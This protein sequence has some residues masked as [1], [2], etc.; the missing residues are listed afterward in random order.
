VTA[1]Y[2]RG[3]EVLK[4]D[5]S[6]QPWWTYWWWSIPWQLG[7][8]YDRKIAVN[9]AA[10]IDCK[11]LLHQALVEDAQAFLADPGEAIFTTQ[12]LQFGNQIDPLR[13]PEQGDPPALVP[14]IGKCEN[15]GVGTAHYAAISYVLFS[16]VHPSLPNPLAPVGTPALCLTVGPYPWIYG[17]YSDL[18][19][20]IPN[21]FNIDMDDYIRDWLTQ[22]WISPANDAANVQCNMQYF[23]PYWCGWGY[24]WWWW[25]GG[26]CIDIGVGEGE[27]LDAEQVTPQ[28]VICA[29]FP[30]V[31]NDGDG[32]YD[33]DPVDGINNDGDSSPIG[34]LIDEDPV[35]C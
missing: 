20:I 14:L 15:Y 16:N 5:I 24:W 27:S 6:Y 34:P 22:R 29:V 12:A 17:R 18:N 30:P 31:D 8:P 25:N 33:E 35:E 11:G 9:P 10:N 26:D 21:N 2:V 13:L 4:K 23:F 19:V 28:R 32:R 1:Q 3:S 7:H